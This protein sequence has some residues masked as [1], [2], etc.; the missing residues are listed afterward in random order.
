MA[1]YSVLIAFHS[2][3]AIRLTR[4]ERDLDDDCPENGAVGLVESGEHQLLESHSSALIENRATRRR[5]GELLVVRYVDQACTS[6][7]ESTNFFEE[8][9]LGRDS[10]RTSSIGNKSSFFMPEKKPHGES[11]SKTITNESY[12]F[13]EQAFE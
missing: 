13:G 7:S 12:F 9:V 8:S 6:L 3:N 5:S 10:N 4:G 1:P 2:F 11:P